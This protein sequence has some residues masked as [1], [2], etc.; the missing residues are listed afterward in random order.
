MS[1]LNLAALLLGCCKDMEPG[2]L[3]HRGWAVALSSGGRSRPTSLGADW[4][5]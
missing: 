4:S 2:R 1:S 5:L 3:A